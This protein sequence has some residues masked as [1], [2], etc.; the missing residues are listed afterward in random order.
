MTKEALKNRLTGFVRIGKLITCL[1]ALFY[2]TQVS[3]ALVQIFHGS[4]SPAMLLIAVLQAAPGFAVIVLS[5]TLFFNVGRTAQPFTQRN[6]RLLRWIAWLLIA[7]ELVIPTVVRL[8]ARLAPP[9]LIDG[10]RVEVHGSMGLV[11]VAVGFA[12]MAISYI[13]EYGVGL[14]QLDDETL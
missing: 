11:L 14:Q 4:L 7:C 13:F 3:L 2:L 8:S 5:L 1:I 9:V 6:V 12:V 10:V